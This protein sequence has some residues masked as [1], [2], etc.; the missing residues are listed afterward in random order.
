MS[1]VGYIVGDARQ[2]PFRG[3][4]TKIPRAEKAKRKEL[5]NF[6]LAQ[7]DEY[8]VDLGARIRLTKRGFEVV[9]ALRQH[10]ARGGSSANFKPPPAT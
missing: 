1:R 9:S 2:Y 5:S 4:R 6:L 8:G 10:L 7:I 3:Y